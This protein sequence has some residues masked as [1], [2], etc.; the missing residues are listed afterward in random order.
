MLDP[1]R[2][3]Y[4]RQLEKMTGLALRAVQREL[5]RFVSVDLLYRHMEGKRAYYQVD[6]HFLLFPE[7]RAMILKT[8]TPEERLRGELTIDTSV[9]QAF[10]VGDEVLVITHG[11][12][13]PTL[14]LPDDIQLHLLS[15]DEFVRRLRGDSDSLKPFL[16]HGIDLLDRRDDVIWHWIETA[17]FSVDTEKD[18]P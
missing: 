5:E 14:C 11:E 4:Q 6:T 3:F 7:L 2:S 9:R 10:R 16:D 17:G 15:S 8:G 13:E 18:V 12:A 1:H